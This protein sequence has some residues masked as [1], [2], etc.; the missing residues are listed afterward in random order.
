MKSIITID[1][2]GSLNSNGYSCV[3]NLD[4]L[5]KITNIQATLFVTPDVIDHNKDIIKEWKD[6]NHTIGL[7][8][9][10]ARLTGRSDWLTEYSKSEVRDMIRRG[11][12]TFET[13]IEAHPR[14]FRAGR[15]EY[16]EELL[17][18]LSDFGFDADASLVP[19]SCRPPYQVDN[20]TELP[21]TTYQNWLTPVLL[22]HRG[23]RSVPLYADWF[24]PKPHYIPGFYF[25]TWRLLHSDND[26]VM[27]AFHDYDLETP[28]FTDR[29]ERY[30]EFLD[31]HST[32]SSL[33]KFL[34]NHNFSNTITS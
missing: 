6:E 24:F 33:G 25:M 26:Y 29:V 11:I 31:K 1:V 12:D 16:S 30:I 23:K 27:T 28:E 13:N 32:V 9:H 21:L 14:V 8:I 17:E 7:H 5:L 20:V 15:W 18:V 4:N 34:D 2:E 19:V 22:R 3:E 10:P